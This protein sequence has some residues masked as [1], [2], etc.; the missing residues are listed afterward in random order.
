[1]ALNPNLSIKPHEKPNKDKLKE[2][3]LNQEILRLMKLNQGRRYVIVGTSLTFMTIWIAFAILQSEV[4]NLEAEQTLYLGKTIETIALAFCILSLACGIALIYIYNKQ[5]RKKKELQELEKDKRDE[6]PEKDGKLE[7]T[8]IYLDTF[9]SFA[10]VI[11]ELVVVLSMWNLISDI[12]KSLGLDSS[13]MNFQGIS[14][15]ISNVICFGAALM[16]LYIAINGQKSNK[17]VGTDK[18]SLINGEESTS[19]SNKKPVIAAW[20]IAT[21]GLLM[22]IRKVLLSLEVTNTISYT[23]NLGKGFNMDTLPLGLIFGIVG[24]AVFLVGFILNM[25]VASN[26]KTQGLE[27]AKISRT[28]EG[29]LGV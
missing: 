19:Q 1:M 23:G 7:K 9:A 22:L 29:S 27:G 21:G 11:T 26:N 4:L 13:A 6:V 18:E 16:F 8:A 17:K 12:N 24:I 25:C 3:E 2:E 28:G 15:T 5:K 20:L 14:D 10:I